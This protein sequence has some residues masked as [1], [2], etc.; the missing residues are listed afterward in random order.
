MWPW[1]RGARLQPQHLLWLPDLG[2]AWEQKCIP[3]VSHPLLFSA[4]SVFLP[5]V[6]SMA[7]QEG[8]GRENLCIACETQ[9]RSGLLVPEALILKQN[10]FLNV[11]ECGK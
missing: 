10:Q 5:P 8:P 11:T 7:A 3:L 9:G 6:C 2:R 4:D 1:L